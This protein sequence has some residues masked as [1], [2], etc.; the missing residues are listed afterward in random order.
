MKLIIIMMGKDT[1]KL[2]D[3]LMNYILNWIIIGILMDIKN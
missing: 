3:Y 1:T 2:N